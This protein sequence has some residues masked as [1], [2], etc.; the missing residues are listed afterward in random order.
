MNVDA[1]PGGSYTH[2]VLIHHTDDELVAATM[3]FVEHGLTSGG[4]VLVHST[5]QRVALLS[6]A[7]GTHPRLAYAFDETLYASP[8]TTLFG[9][10]RSLAQRAEPGDFWVT[11]TVP[12]GPD[13]AGDA[14]WTRYESLVNETLGGYAF[15]ALCSYDTRTLSAATVAAALVTHPNVSDGVTRVDSPSYLAPGDFLCD[16]RARVPGPPDDEPIAGGVVWM[17]SDLSAARSLIGQLGRVATALDRETVDGFAVAVNEVLDNG[18]RH[19]RPPV[20]FTLWADTARLGCLVIDLG[21]GVASEVAGYVYPD[22]SEPAGLWVAR[23]L[24][25]EL[26]IRNCPSGTEV[27]LRIG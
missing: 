7:L 3:A 25:D 6:A 22:P 15:H 8:M 10:A 2:D 17:A 1:I 26:V 19:G 27:F 5:R 13:E 23:Q 11:G 24:C 21:S 4:S 20:T 9:Y 14:A 12:F 16:P 18:L